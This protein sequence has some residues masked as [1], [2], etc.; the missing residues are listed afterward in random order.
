MFCCYN[1]PWFSVLHGFRGRFCKTSGVIFCCYNVLSSLQTLSG[2]AYFQEACGALPVFTCQCLA[3]FS[4]PI[5]G[6][7]FLALSDKSSPKW[8]EIGAESCRTGFETRLRSNLLY[9]RLA[10][11][12]SA[13][14]L[15]F[16]RP[17]HALQ[18]G[19]TSF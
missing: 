10:T 19:P 9:A 12:P 3:W 2:R 4:G 6:V 13:L 5:V 14:M 18:H 7:S 11:N 1:A 8:L 16:R 17:Q 15:A